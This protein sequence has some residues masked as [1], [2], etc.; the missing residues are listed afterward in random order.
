MRIGRLRV[1]QRPALATFTALLAVAALLTPLWAAEPDRASG[2]LLLGGVGAE[3]A[4][5]FRR[6]TSAAQRSAWASAG[7]TLLLALVLLNTS[8][9][10]ATALAIFVAAPFALDAAQTRSCRDPSGCRWQSVP[11]RCVG[12]ARQSGRCRS[13]CC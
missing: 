12:R 7:V 11:A 8:W 6:R 10:A 1:E 5:S 9:L 13:A 3:L 2:L 4:H